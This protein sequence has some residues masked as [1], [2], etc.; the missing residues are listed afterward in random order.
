MQNTKTWQHSNQSRFGSLLINGMA[1]NGIQLHLTDS[2]ICLVTYEFRSTSRSKRV[3]KKCIRPLGVKE[4]I[5]GLWVWRGSVVR[6][7]LRDCEH[8]H[9]YNVV[10][11][12]D[13]TWV[14]PICFLRVKLHCIF[15]GYVH[16]Q[17]CEDA[18]RM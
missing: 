8:S 1:T 12:A 6:I 9:K 17:L 2:Y 10:S 5:R 15:C 13:D 4:W 14:F 16:L 3:W 7:P 11:D 18:S